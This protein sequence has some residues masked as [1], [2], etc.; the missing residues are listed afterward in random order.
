LNRALV[1]VLDGV[2]VGALPDAD[3]YGDGGS[4]TLAH[5]AAAVGGLCLPGLEALGLG[6]VAR[7]A[8]LSAQAPGDGAY[9]RMAEQSP[10]KDSISGH[11]ELMGVVLERAFPTYP[12]G[13]PPDVVASFEKRIGRPVLWNRPASGTEV[14]ARLGDEHV[15]S[16]SPIL[17][18][19]ADSVFQLA[20]HEDVIPPEA[21]YRMC[22]AARDLLVGEHGVA[23]VIA[24]PFCGSSG[25][26]ERTPGRRDFALPPVGETLLD[27]LMA[28]G[29]E[30]W[31]VGK[32]GD[33]F[34]SRGFTRSIK[35]GGNEDCLDRVLELFAGLG[36]GLLVVTLVD[37]DMLWGHR[38]DARAFADGLAAFDRRLGQLR[39]LLTENDVLVLTADHGCD[40]TTPSTDHS[41]EYVPALLWGPRVRRDV[42][43]GTRASF[44]DL[45]ATLGE[46]FGISGIGRTS[47]FQEI[48]T[49][50]SG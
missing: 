19:S 5:T 34:A 29:L 39:S 18:T 21:L 44:A 38:N 30:T 42:N 2:G 22:E 11:W 14:I 32:V 41:R 10:G 8:G 16:G 3:L 12:E 31:G 50:R 17:Y 43:V 20:A 23:R 9:G 7:I 15:S 48:W 25:R 4:D 6:R 36:R 49:E 33:L 47:F 40:P 27:R 13:F 35:A 28:E 26:Y 45:A 1:V 46:G 37:F 24:R